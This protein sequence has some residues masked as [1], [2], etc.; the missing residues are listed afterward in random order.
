MNF[1]EWES[2]LWNDRCQEAFE[3]LKMILCT[4]PVITYHK[5]GSKFIIDT[6]ANYIGIGELLSQV[7]MEKRRLSVT[8][9]KSCQSQK[10]SIALHAENCWQ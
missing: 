5:K 3:Q 9:V 2:F 1:S 4:S 8:L 6:D 7:Q 10:E